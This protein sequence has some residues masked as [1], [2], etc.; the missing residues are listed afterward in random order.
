MIHIGLLT[1][2][3]NPHSIKI[4]EQDDGRIPYKDVVAFIAPRFTHPVALHTAI[5]QYLLW[6]IFI[7]C[8]FL[9]NTKLQKP[10][11]DP[12]KCIQKVTLT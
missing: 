9:H 4:A 6:L 8:Y 12:V 11:A 5:I 10:F 2:H 3:T 1:I 7:C